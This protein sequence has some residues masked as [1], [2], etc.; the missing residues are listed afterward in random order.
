VIIGV[1]VADL[2]R[3]PFEVVGLQAENDDDDC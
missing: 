3:Q 2:T 1:A